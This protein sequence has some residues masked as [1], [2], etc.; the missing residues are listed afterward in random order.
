MDTPTT[1]MIPDTNTGIAY[2]LGLIFHPAVVMLPT[3]WIILSDVP[4]QDAII[5]IGITALVILI[6]GFTMIAILKQQQKYTYQR[7]S[8]APLYITAWLS[9]ITC[10]LFILFLNGPKVLLLCMATLVVWLPVQLAINHSFTKIS[11]HTGV[12][13][14]CVTALMMLGKLPNPFAIILGFIIIGLTA[15]ARVVTKNHTRL[16]VIL[17]FIVG[18]GSVLLVFSLLRI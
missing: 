11:T 1:D 18:A 3:L 8:R 5:W 9:V 12:I 16:Q 17:G 7:R 14:G 2:W 10:L 4:L 15:W 13:T 6:P